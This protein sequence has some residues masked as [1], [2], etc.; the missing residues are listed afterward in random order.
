MLGFMG[1]SEFTRN[2]L[3]SGLIQANRKAELNEEAPNPALLEL[4]TKKLVKLL[5]YQK[6]GRPL[7]LNF[8]SCT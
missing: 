8:G 3:K 4:T 6:P 1:T 7:V 2:Q 5:D